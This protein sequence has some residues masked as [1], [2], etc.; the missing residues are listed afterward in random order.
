MRA[1][2]VT[3][4]ELGFSCI[5]EIYEIGGSLDSVIT[6][7][8]HLAKKKSGRVF[9]DDFCREKGVELFKLRNINDP[10][11]IEF[12]RS[13]DLDWLFIIG[14]SQ[15]AHAEV[16]RVPREG[17]V[18]MHPTLLPVGRGRASIPWAIVRGLNETGVT[19]FQLDEGVDT[20]PILDQV[21]IPL[22]DRETA[23]MLYDKVSV[24][25]RTLI[26]KAWPA[27][28]AGTL[29]RQPQDESKATFWPGRTPD[30]GRLEPTMTVSQVDTLVRATTHPYPG[31]FIDD[32]RVRLRIWSGY[33]SSAPVSARGGMEPLVLKFA[34]GSFTATDYCREDSIAPEV[35]APKH[36]PATKSV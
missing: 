29:R 24:A 8:D 19:L 34:D 31:A 30:D 7:H 36:E 6:L 25:H 18:G 1:G 12:L 28:V 3:C 26:R 20:G 14:W 11:A 17:V 5:R 2:F 22:S 32:G 16:L 4:V 27:M 35:T 23:T 10:D 13:R 21:T 9:V 15:I 33:P